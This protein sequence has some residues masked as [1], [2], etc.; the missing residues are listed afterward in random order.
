M[1]TLVFVNLESFNQAEGAQSS[2]VTVPIPKDPYE[3]IRQTYLV[4]TDIESEP[5]RVR[6]GHLNS[7]V[8]LL[9][10]HPLTH[11][12]PVLV[13][14]LHR[15]ARMA[16][17]VP[18]AMSPGLSAGIGEVVAMSDLAFRKGFRS[19]YDSLP[20]PTLPVQKGYRGT[21]EIILGTDSEEDEEVKESLDS[22]S[23]N[24]GVKDEGP[25]AKDKDLAAGDEG[26][27]AGVKDPGVD[28]ES[29]GLDFESHSM[30]DER[31]GLDEE[32]RSVKIDG[33]G[34][35]EDEEEAVPRGQ[36]Q[37]ASV[38]RKAVSAPLG[39]GYGALRCRELALEGDHVYSTFEPTLTTWTD[40]KDGMVSIDVPIYPPSAPPVQT[41][42]S[43]EWTSGSLP[44]SPSPSFVPSLVSSPMI[45]LTVPSPTAL[46]MATSTATIPVNE[47]PF[48]EVGAQLE[49]YRSILQDHT[50]RLDVMPPTRF[51]EIDRDARELYTR[52]R[53]VKDEIFSQRYQFRSLEHEQERTIRELHELRGRVTA[54][55]QERDRREQ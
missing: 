53:E 15:T 36:Q 34:L 10:D 37:A 25:T 51:V 3:A 38:M 33:L 32:G 19:S 50:Q 12:T 27:A 55:E 31:H 41:P 54:L 43:H 11:T 45:Q 8:P 30:D 46:H 44:I 23:E 40:P 13:P 18:S 42:P 17:H 16:V 14:I 39:L 9:P 52:S 28:D 6:L 5:F 29:Y 1:S 2:R 22:D 7:T 4:G 47:D 35:E 48:I 26:L 21:S 20:S 49:L 24:E